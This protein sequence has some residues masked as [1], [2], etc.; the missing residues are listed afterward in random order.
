M[1]NYTIAVAW[2]GKDALSD[3]DA[4]KV[5][6][7]A[8]FNTEFSAVQSAVNTKANLNGSGSESFTCN[9]LTATSGTITTGTV[10][11]LNS[12]TG[13]VATLNSTTGTVTT[14]NSTTGTIATLNSTTANVATIDLGN[15]TVTETGGVLL[16]ATGGTNKMKL[17]ADGSLT[18]VGDVTAYGT[19]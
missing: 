3:S 1:S 10:T 8:D 13:T 9:A 15:W 4:A 19:I 5:I 11:T 16:F 17:A 2:S 7:G 14:L 18:V 12:T 6:S